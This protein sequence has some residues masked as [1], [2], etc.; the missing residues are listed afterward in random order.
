MRTTV[1]IEKRGKGYLSTVRGRHGGGHQSARCG[2]TPYDAAASAARLMAEY[3]QGNPEGGDLMAPPEVLEIVPEH[4][5]SIPHHPRLG[6]FEEESDILS[7]RLNLPRHKGDKMYT[8][9]AKTDALNGSVIIEAS[10]IDAAAIIFGRPRGLSGDNCR[11][12]LE[13]VAEID[14]AWMWIESDDAPDGDR[15]GGS[16]HETLQE[17]LAQ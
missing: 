12:V 10:T 17:Y 13:S 4:L 6:G 2:L 11:E 9:T 15:R 5:R 8:Y 14:G 16:S 7:M 1:I 3:A